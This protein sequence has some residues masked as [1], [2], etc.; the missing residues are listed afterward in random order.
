M[1]GTLFEFHNTNTLRLVAF[2]SKIPDANR[3][4]CFIVLGG[5]TD[6][7][8][9]VPYVQKLSESR[10]TIQPL[11]TSSCTGFGI[12]SIDNDALEL[13]VLLD[14]EKLSQFRSLVLVGHSTGCQILIRFLRDKLMGCSAR[15]RITRVI[16][17]APVSDRQGFLNGDED[18]TRMLSWATTEPVPHNDAIYSAGLFCGSPINAFRIRS[19]LTRLGDEDFFS[20]DLSVSEVCL[21]IHTTRSEGITLLCPLK[22]EFLLSGDEEYIPEG[23]F[24]QF[25]QFFTDVFSTAV[26]IEYP[27]WEIEVH[28]IEGANHSCSTN[29]DGVCS[30][31][32]QLPRLIVF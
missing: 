9:S 15:D 21:Q 3:D 13:R 19:L 32:L 8:M 22:L 20:T 10:C 12:S 30:L 17:Q 28:V 6:G 7:L 11:F 24:N 14:H 31:L 25:H 16:L 26:K 23:S 29:I 4:E 5:L 27:N 1:E 18:I 2:Q